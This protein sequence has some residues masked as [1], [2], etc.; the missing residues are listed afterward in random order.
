MAARCWLGNVQSAQ[1][2]LKLV[3]AE[4]MDETK[5]LVGEE[6]S[7][8]SRQLDPIFEGIRAAE[9]YSSHLVYT[10]STIPIRET[11]SRDVTRYQKGSHIR[12]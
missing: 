4:Q 8:K 2:C 5:T 12:F 11:R 6:S 10:P 1:L 3:C 9:G 7:V